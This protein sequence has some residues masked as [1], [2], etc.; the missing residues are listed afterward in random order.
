MGIDPIEALLK[1]QP[2]TNTSKT[3]FFFLNEIR[4]CRKSKTHA[5]AWIPRID[6]NGFM[7]FL[8]TG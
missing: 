4:T 6:V 2:F 8:A 1:I 3:G 7:R 5:G